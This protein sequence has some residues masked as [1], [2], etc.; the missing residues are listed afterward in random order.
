ME[1]LQEIVDGSEERHWLVGTVAEVTGCIQ[2]LKEIWKV[3]REAALTRWERFIK[4]S[5]QK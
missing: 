1:S 5:E 3:K 4:Q 2:S